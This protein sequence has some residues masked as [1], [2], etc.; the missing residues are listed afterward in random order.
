MK[1]VNT[2]NEIKIKLDQ[3]LLDRYIKLDQTG[4][5][6]IPLEC[7]FSASKPCSPE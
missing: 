3:I 4:K 6:T 5:F 7:I 2:E 1:D